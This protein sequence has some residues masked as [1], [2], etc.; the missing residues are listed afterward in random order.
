MSEQ[1]NI[2]AVQVFAGEFWQASTIQQVLEGNSIQ[3]F[4]E[5]EH[6]GSIAPWRV[7]AGGFNPVKVIVSNNDY[8]LAIKLINEF[9]GAPDENESDDISDIT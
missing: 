2:K 5:N 8:D 7:E 4:L 3:A 6:M 9:N 1:N